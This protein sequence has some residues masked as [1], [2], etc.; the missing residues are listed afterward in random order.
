[1]GDGGPRQQQDVTCQTTGQRRPL[2][3]GVAVFEALRAVFWGPVDAGPASAAGHRHSPRDP[4][5]NAQ[6]GPRDRQWGISA[7]R[8]DP[9][10]HLMSRD[11]GSRRAATAGE[12]MKVA[13]T[14]G[15]SKDID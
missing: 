13:G 4:V 11:Q 1:M 15:A 2:H 5:P 9:P 6:R 8:R 10:H 14:E 12:G 7:E 3:G